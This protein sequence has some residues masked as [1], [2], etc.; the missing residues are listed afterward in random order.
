V[1]DGRIKALDGV[2]AVAIGCVLFG[3][4]RGALPARWQGSP[5]IPLPYGGFGVQVFF[6][7]SGF[8]ITGLLADERARHGR[9]RLRSFYRRRAYRILPPY[10]VMLLV[11]AVLGAAGVVSVTRGAWLSAATFSWNYSPWANGWWL[12]HTWSLAVEEQFYLLWPVAFVLLGTRRGKAALLG[13][14]AATPVVR[15]LTAHTAQAGRI[16]AMFHTRGDALAIGCLLAL[17]WRDPRTQVLFD[18]LIAR[19]AQW[20]AL[21]CLPLSWA[22]NGRYGTRWMFPAGYTLDAVAVAFLLGYVLLRPPRWLTS[23]AVV[24]GGLVSYSLYLWQQWF[25]RPGGL[26]VPLALVATFAAAEAS[27]RLVERPALALRRL[28]EPPEVQQLPAHHH[29]VAGHGGV[30]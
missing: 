5:R 2:R 11:A 26:P 8:L 13:F 14:A 28:R 21:A 22:L 24:H 27:Y 18:R 15:V 9:V 4:A 6:V 1:A 23:R 19:G 3:H 10:A 20:V 25:L 16:P 30:A 7:L 12:G 29:Q 17:A